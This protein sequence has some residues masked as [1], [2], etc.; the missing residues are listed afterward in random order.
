MAAN[1]TTTAKT[2]RNW[3]YLTVKSIAYG[4]FAAGLGLSVQHTFDFFHTTLHTQ[5]VSALFVPAFI[6]GAQLIGRLIQGDSFTAK[7]NKVGRWLQG[8][9]AALSLAANLIAGHT[10]GDKISGA[11]FVIGYIAFEMIA[12]AIRPVT[13]D[14][15]VIAVTQAAAKSATR[16]A[17]A[18]KA[19][20]TRKANA[21]AKAQAEADRK[22]RARLNRAAK[23]AEQDAFAK[24]TIPAPV[25]PAPFDYDTIAYV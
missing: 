21:A 18:Q 7:T 3:T 24:A 14:A 13:E 10:I 12:H 9:G 6:D 20:A 19:A 4:A 25:S 15:A 16:S 8:I 23:Q 11:I 22:E 5:F 17:A 2:P 1:T